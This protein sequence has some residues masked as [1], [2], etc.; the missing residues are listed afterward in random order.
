MDSQYTGPLINW[1]ETG[2]DEFRRQEELKRLQRGEIQDPPH[3]HNAPPP[4]VYYTRAECFECGNPECPAH[5]LQ[6]RHYLDKS[7]WTTH[8]I[9]MRAAYLRNMRQPG[10]PFQGGSAGFMRK[11]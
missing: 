11:Y 6:V 1:A 9:D 4:G 5:G 10:N 7:R 8:K 2:I 3:Y